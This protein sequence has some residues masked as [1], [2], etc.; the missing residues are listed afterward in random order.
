MTGLPLHLLRGGERWRA[1]YACDPA[2]SRGRLYDE[3]DDQLRSP[4]QRDRDRIIHSNAF[5]RLKHK[6]QV[7]IH[8]EGDHFRTRLTHTLEV[9]QIARSIARPLGLDE[10]LAEALALAHDLGHPPFGHAGERALDKALGPYEGFDHNAQSLRVATQL[11]RRYPAIRWPQP[12][13]GDAGGAGQA[14]RSAAR[15]RPAGTIGAHAGGK[16]PYAIRAYRDRQDLEL[17]KFAS[18]EA[19]AAAISDDIAYDCHDSGGWAA[20]RPP[21]PRRAR[22]S[23]VGRRDPDRRF[24]GVPGLES[25]RVTHELIRR[26]ISVMIYDVHR[27]G[28]ARGRSRAH[29]FR[30]RRA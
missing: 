18:L 17:D 5:R 26:V 24:A 7:F 6:T 21:L 14:Q 8:H 30:W 27:R 9:A 2:Q 4:F 25:F 28:S 29:R 16:L 11:E 10:D 23:A 12:D 19:Q 1:P 22:G 20:S 3:P 13:L 15:P